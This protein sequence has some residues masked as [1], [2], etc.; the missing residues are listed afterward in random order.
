VGLIKQIKNT[1]YA[2]S[3]RI[4]GIDAWWQYNHNGN[5]YWCIGY[6]SNLFHREDGP[7]IEYVDGG[8]E[9]WI[10]GEHIKQLDNKKIYGKENLTKYLT[11][12]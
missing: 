9:Y 5:T 4:E 11:L 3:K 6:D 1:L 12:V 8:T 10:D 2:W 7:A